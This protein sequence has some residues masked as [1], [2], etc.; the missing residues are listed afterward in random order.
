[1]SCLFIF[2]NFLWFWVHSA[3]IYRT[4]GIALKSK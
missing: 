3:G 2:F 4:L 1:L